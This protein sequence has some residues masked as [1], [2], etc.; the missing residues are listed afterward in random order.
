MQKVGRSI[1]LP[2]AV[3]DGVATHRGVVKPLGENQGFVLS[4]AEESGVRLTD[5]LVVLKDRLVCAF[6]TAA[7]GGASSKVVTRELKAAQCIVKLT[8]VGNAVCSPVVRKERK[9]VHHFVKHTAAESGVCTTA[10]GFALKAFT[11]ERTFV[12]LTVAA[13]GV[14]S[15]DVR[16]AHV[17]G[18]I[19]V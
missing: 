18:L 3:G 17:A 14:Q 5:V 1:A 2:T 19:A 13:R 7:A 9:A 10:V 4:T 15:P 6:L 16:K 11:E 12:S 8:V